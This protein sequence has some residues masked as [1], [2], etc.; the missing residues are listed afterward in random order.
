M[1]SKPCWKRRPPTAPPMAPAPKTTKR[2][3]ALCHGRVPSSGRGVVEPGGARRPRWAAPSPPRRCASSAAW[4]RRPAAT[5][6]ATCGA[7]S[8]S[9]DEPAPI[10]TDPDEAYLPPDGVAR[11]GPRRSAHHA[12]RRRQRAAAPDAAPAGHGRRGGA[13]QLPGGPS[14][15]AAPDRVL[16]RH[17]DLRHGGRGGGRHRPGPPRPPPRQG[18]RARRAALLGRRP[19]AGHLHP[20][21]RGVE[22]PGLV[23]ALRQPA[24]RRPRSATA[25]TRRWR[26]WR[27]PSGR[28]G[29]RARPPRWRATCCACGPSSTPARRPGP[30][31]TGCCAAWP[32]GRASGPCTPSCV[33]AAVGVL[34]GWARRE[35]GL[36]IAGP[37]DLLVDTAAVTPLTRGLSTALRW[38]VTPPG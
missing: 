11:T 15:P 35:L 14:G 31:G 19:R 21:R 38:I 8:A 3:A 32:G 22:L 17:D 29:C 2:M 7:P 5:W 12:D 23:A 26:R 20:R 16:R 28:R 25:T 4:P 30:P 6:R 37:L 24:A 27:W 9:G 10:A 1:T 34:P 13:L 36:S 33:A 18:H